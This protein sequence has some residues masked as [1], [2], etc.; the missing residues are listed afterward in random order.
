M[1]VFL[2]WSG[3]RS[4]AVAD[5]LRTWLPRVIQGIRPWMS[6]ADI[7]AGARWLAEVSTMLDATGIGVVCITPENVSSPWLN[8]EAG[9]LS[10]VLDQS[11]VCPVALGMS[12]GQVSGPLSQ[13]Q[14][15]T[16]DKPGLLKVLATLNRTLDEKA[17]PEG[18]LIEIY[19]VWWPKLEEKL[20]GIPATHAPHK[21]RQLEDQ[22]EELLQISREQLRREN[23]R[24]EASRSR[25]EKL[26]GVIQLMERASSMLPA[27]KAAQ[28]TH[29]GEMRAAMQ[30]ALASASAGGKSGFEDPKD[31]VSLISAMTQALPQPASI[32]LDTQAMAEMADHLKQMQDEDRVRVQ[33]MLSTPKDTKPDGGA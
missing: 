10:K 27:L 21:T 25:D 16:L 9:A 22:V 12:P 17:L 19:E 15:V 13:F 5:A 18:E 24:L 29:L 1:Q 3:D 32:D 20:N 33:Q 23:I 30:R 14:A 31:L 7:G 28:S 26:D 8:F 2:S 11:R 4:R 6:D